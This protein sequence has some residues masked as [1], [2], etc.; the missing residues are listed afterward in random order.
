MSGHHNLSIFTKDDNPWCKTCRNSEQIKGNR[1]FRNGA[2]ICYGDLKYLPTEY[3]C[4]GY[5]QRSKEKIKHA[6]VV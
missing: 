4:G 5:L 3:S 1:I 2:H 6:P